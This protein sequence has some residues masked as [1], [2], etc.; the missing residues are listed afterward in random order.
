M[1]VEASCLRLCTAV[2]K[3]VRVTRGVTDIKDFPGGVHKCTL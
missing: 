1:E 3:G 2:S